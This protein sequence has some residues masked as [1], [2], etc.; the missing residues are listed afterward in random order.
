M[1]ARQTFNRTDEI[2]GECASRDHG[3]NSGRATEAAK[4]HYASLVRVV[5]SIGSAMHVSCAVLAAMDMHMAGKTIVQVNRA[6]Q[7]YRGLRH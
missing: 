3:Q 1:I 4:R 2:E 6:A 5:I 7:R